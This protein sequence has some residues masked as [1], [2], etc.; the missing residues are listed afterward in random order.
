MSKTKLNQNSKVKYDLCIIGGAG[1]VGLPFGVVAANKGI[2][3]VL[4]DINK[5]SLQTIASGKFPFKEDLGDRELK[6]ALRKNKLFTS[7]KPEVVSE[8]GVVALMTG[9]PIDE[10]LNPNLKALMNVIEFYTP[11]FRDGQVLVL[12]STV[13]PGTT[14]RIQNHF[15]NLGKN[16]HVAFC[17]ERIAQGQAIKEFQ[18]LPQIVAGATLAAQKEAEKLFH[19]LTAMPIIPL[20]PMEAELTK[21]Y[22][23]TWR[24]IQFAVANQFFMIA[25]DHGLDYQKIYHAMTQNYPRMKSIPRPGFAAGPCLLKDTM[26]LASFYGNNFNLGHSA[27]L[28]NEGLPNHL[29]RKLKREFKLEDYPQK[30]EAHVASMDTFARAL[31]LTPTPHSKTVGILGMA[32]KAESDDA[33]DSLSYKLKRLA[34]AEF[35]TVLCH[36]PYI[37]DAHFVS[38]DTLLNKSDVVILATPHDEYNKIDPKKYPQKTF[39][40]IWH[41]WD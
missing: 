35:G 16:I 25:D 31:R 7:L 17:P 14:D 21:L 33:R 37:N 18:E 28:V 13:F 27:M 8:S 9:T 20:Q 34:E 19:R 41:F 1:H 38:V 32:F 22:T 12:R 15:K 3:T 39:V 2:S 23:N 4:L 5:K 26:Q 6:K 40:D 24:Y 11:Y 36:D 10:Y 29:M 30:L